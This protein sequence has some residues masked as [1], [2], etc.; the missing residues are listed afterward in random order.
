[1]ATA[2]GLAAGTV[3]ALQRTFET[4]PSTAAKGY[5]GH[6]G[7]D[8]GGNAGGDDGGCGG[9]NGG[10]NVGGGGRRDGGKSRGC[11]RGDTAEKIGCGGVVVLTCADVASS[12]GQRPEA[13]KCLRQ[14]RRC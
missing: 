7:G 13:L 5:R 2:I 4:T 6:G 14:D 10:R 11:M 9:G 8:D 1:M 3:A 12:R